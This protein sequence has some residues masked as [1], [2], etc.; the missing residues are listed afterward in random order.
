MSSLTYLEQKKSQ[1]IEWCRPPDV[2]KVQDLVKVKFSGAKPT[3]M[4]S[5][6]DGEGRLAAQ[7]D[8]YEGKIHSDVMS[9][10][11]AAKDKGT[12]VLS[13]FDTA[14]NAEFEFDGE[15][16]GEFEEV[17]GSAA[18]QALSRT[19]NDDLRIKYWY[20]HWAHCAYFYYFSRVACTSFVDKVQEILVA[21]WEA[22]TFSKETAIAECVNMWNELKTEL[23][24][25]A[26]QLREK[27]PLIPLLE[28]L[29]YTTDR[30][31][32]M[33]SA[34]RPSATT[35]NYLGVVKTTRLLLR[36]VWVLRFLTLQL[37]TS[38]GITYAPLIALHLKLSHMKKM[39]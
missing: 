8:V 36:R 39:V 2:V 22:N 35:D 28:F 10:L 5:T 26:E 17:K 4:F 31:L 3:V 23:T 30:T 12:L 6:T 25:R 11:N 32:V 33:E 19:R 1:L 38:C 9:S 14:Y 13:R 37:R 7:F 21:H 34:D 27:H 18:Q 29:S 20:H 24:S 15:A 16:I